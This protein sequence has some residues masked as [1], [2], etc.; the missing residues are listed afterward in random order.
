MPVSGGEGHPG[1]AQPVYV[2]P[3]SQDIGI[4]DGILKLVPRS[5]SGRPHMPIDYFLRTLAE[6]QGSRGVAVILSGTATDGTLGL[7]AIKAEGGIAFA[8]DPSSAQF[9]GMPRSAIAAGGVDFILSPEGIAK[10]LTRR[11]ASAPAVARRSPS[12]ER[13]CSRPRRRQ[14]SPTRSSPR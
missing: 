3:P 13:P 6:V 12:P 1:G 2:I 5:E 11:A 4:V 8:Q 10:E 14:G 9:D 7:K